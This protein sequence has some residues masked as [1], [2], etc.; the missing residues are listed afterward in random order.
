MSTPPVVIFSLASCQYPSDFLD[1]M[2]SDADPG[3]AGTSTGLADASMIALGKLQGGSDRP[4]LS[5][6]VGDQ[7]YIDATAGLFD[8]KTSDDRYLQPYR[9]LGASRGHLEAIQGSGVEWHMMPDDHEISDNWEPGVPTPP[10]ERSELELGLDAYWKYPRQGE[11]P[12]VV[13]HTVLHRELPFFLADARTERQGRNSA[14]FR[15][16]KIMSDEQFQALHDWM[17]RP[18]YTLLPKFVTTASALFPR[19]LAVARDPARALHSDAWD[20]Y[21]NSMHGLLAYVCEHEVKG[22]VFLSGDEHISNCVQVHLTRLDVKGNV[23]KSCTLHSVHS[24]ALYAPY[25][26][27]NAVPED[28]ARS[29]TFCFPD[30][31]A[32]PYTCEVR[33]L[34]APPGDG[35]ALLKVILDGAAWRLEV[36]FHDAKGPKPGQPVRLDILEA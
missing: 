18:A 16:Q 19:S 8:P 12:G 29:E 28:F 10:G 14:N 17:V 2:P 5:L 23:C 24:S 35:F 30:P 32:G 25:P 36:A 3:M 27:A 21:P 22:L 9:N 26:F 13:W 11:P 4:S 15:S 1:R 33:T 34:F 20:G 6:F 7:V 31:D